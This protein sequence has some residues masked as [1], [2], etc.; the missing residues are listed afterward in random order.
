MFSQKT[1]SS[2][3]VADTSKLGKRGLDQSQVTDQGNQGKKSTQKAEK[4]RR[5]V[6]D[7][8]SD[9]D[10]PAMKA[11]KTK[12]KAT[13]EAAKKTTM[14]TADG[15]VRVGVLMY[16][17]DQKAPKVGEADGRFDCNV[18][19]DWYHSVITGYGRLSELKDRYGRSQKCVDG[20]YIKRK[21]LYVLLD[22]TST[23]KCI[24]E[25]LAKDGIKRKI[26]GQEYWHSESLVLEGGCVRAVY[27]GMPYVMNVDP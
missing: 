9:D 1:A 10:V 19:G 16:T 11:A 26:D 14:K 21:D 25:A 23:K 22:G 15:L 7:L 6:V 17:Q 8:T 2:K 20:L 24:D 5:D 12:V 13:K 18:Y 27:N 4:A 3:K